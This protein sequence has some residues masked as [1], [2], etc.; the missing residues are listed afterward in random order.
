MGAGTTGPSYILA[1]QLTFKSIDNWR[2]MDLDRELYF[3]TDL[4]LSNTLIKLN[5]KSL[6][7][8]SK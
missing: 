7:K 6:I 1:E 8:S 5:Q 4:I 2:N 3:V